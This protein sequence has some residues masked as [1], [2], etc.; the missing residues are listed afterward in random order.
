MP[1]CS[2]SQVRDM[3]LAV[4][5]AIG[6][7][8]AAQELD[9]QWR[10]FEIPEVG[11]SDAWVT[12]HVGL[13]LRSMPEQWQDMTIRRALSRAADY[14]QADAKLAWSY[15]NRLPNDTD[16]TAHVVLFLQRM[17]RTPPSDS[18]RFLLDHQRPDGGFATFLPRSGMPGG[19]SW[20]GSHPD[21]TAVAVRAL[22]PFAMAAEIADSIRRARSYMRRIYR[23]EGCWPVFWWRLDWFTAANWIAALREMDAEPV[24][25]EHVAVGQTPRTRCDLDAALLLE[26][27]TCLGARV[28]AR[29][30][31]ERLV[32]RQLDS[33]LWPTVPVLRVTRPEVLRPWLAPDGGPLYA[34]RRGIYS[35]AT[36]AASIAWFIPCIG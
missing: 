32:E 3:D 12:A 30:V 5:R 9:G 29:S 21:V 1:R 28:R 18:L 33:G 2:V 31:A 15:S 19:H 13:K 17:G 35:G 11:I 6:A 22:S 36:I 14:L 16:S 25:M 4:R 26:A 20:C 23:E 34:D 7:L 24:E 10:D 27:L 8:V